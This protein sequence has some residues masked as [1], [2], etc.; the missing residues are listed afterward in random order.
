VSLSI[1][2][3][4]LHFTHR[5]CQCP[6]QISELT[7]PVSVP[8]EGFGFRSGILRPVANSLCYLRSPSPEPDFGLLV[9]IAP[10][11]YQAHR[12]VLAA[13]GFLYDSAQF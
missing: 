2:F 9:S 3:P 13:T 8:L 6:A 10:V 1:P 4:V 12:P 5:R 7:G 11:S